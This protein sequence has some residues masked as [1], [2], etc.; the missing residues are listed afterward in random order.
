M[1]GNDLS[2]PRSRLTSYPHIFHKSLSGHETD[3]RYPIDTF[4]VNESGWTTCK[5]CKENGKRI[6]S[7]GGC[8]CLE[9]A[10]YV[11]TSSIWYGKSRHIFDL[12]P[13]PCKYPIRVSILLFTEDS[14]ASDLLPMGTDPSRLPAPFR[15]SYNIGHFSA[16]SAS[17]KTFSRASVHKCG[18]CI[19]CM[20]SS[21][22]HNA[23]SPKVSP[24]N[25]KNNTIFI[26]TPFFAYM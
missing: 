11:S 12:L 4:P 5:E 9:L 25:F 3:V 19:S 1:A 21:I 15:Q 26:I 7:S 18:W 8:I 22:S 24:P 13:E 14:P 23:I 2:E 20:D 17:Y 10:G 16:I 6:P